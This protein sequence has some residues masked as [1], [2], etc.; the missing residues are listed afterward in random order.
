MTFREYFDPLVNAA[1]VHKLPNR[2]YLF[3]DEQELT[4]I[5]AMVEGLVGRPYFTKAAPLGGSKAHQ[6]TYSGFDFFL[7]ETEKVGSLKV[8]VS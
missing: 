7:V 1:L 2:Q 4:D 3:V 5:L 8:E 6:I